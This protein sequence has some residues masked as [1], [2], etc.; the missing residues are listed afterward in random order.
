MQ[1]PTFRARSV[2]EL[3]DAAVQV[4]RARFVALVLATLAITF[5]SIVVRLVLPDWEN[6]AFLLDFLLQSLAAASV[7]LIVSDAYLGREPDLASVFRRTFAR[8][9]PLLGASFLQ[10]VAFFLGVFLCVVPGIIALIVT[11]AMPTV[12]VLEGAGA[13]ASFRRSNELARDQW[14]RITGAYVLIFLFGIAVVIGLGVVARLV[15]GDLLSRV[16]TILTDLAVYPFLAV[17]G[18]L[19]YYDIRIRKEAFDIQ[20]LLDEVDALVPA[21]VPPRD[22]R[23]PDPGE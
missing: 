14:K 21:A 23:E 1:A 9:G 8:I 5:P 2:P 20:M 19:L 3:L 12:V 11:F 10:T 18:T 4:V 7:V 22:A 16:A 17:V 15:G 13:F 6:L